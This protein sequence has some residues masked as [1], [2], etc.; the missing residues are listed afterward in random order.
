MYV[1]FIYIKIGDKNSFIRLTVLLDSVF[2]GLYYV[3]IK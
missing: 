2:F 3:K 1:K